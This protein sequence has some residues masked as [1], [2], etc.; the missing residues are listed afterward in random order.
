MSPE[1][2]KTSQQRGVLAGLQLK[3]LSCCAGSLLK[4]K[5]C[6]FHQELL[7]THKHSAM[8]S[9]TWNMSGICALIGLVSG[10]W[11]QHTGRPNSF[12]NLS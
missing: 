7:Y 6:W 3:F 10:W 12:K 2:L 11:L 1:L 4:A 9:A 8:F 5:L